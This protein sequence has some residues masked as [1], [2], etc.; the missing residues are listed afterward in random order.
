MATTRA[1]K[2]QVTTITKNNLKII[3]DNVLY[4]NG[5][6]T[7][8]YCVRLDNYSTASGT[9]MDE[10][11]MRLVN[12][13]S[14]LTLKTPEV[15]FTIERIEKVTEACNV[16]HNLIDTV[17]MYKPDYDLPSDFSK[18]VKKDIQDYCL[19]GIDI[20]QSSLVDVEDYTM[21]ET[22]KAIVRRTVNS[23]AGLG[24]MKIDPE[25]IL[26]IE[27]GIYQTIRSN[28]VRATREL[29]FYNY[30]SKVYPGYEISYDNNGWIKG[31][32]YED[33]MGSLTQTVSDNFGWFEL[34]NEGIDFFG[35]EPQN[36][37][38]CMIDIKAFPP[39]IRS[40][41]N[42]LNYFPHVVTTIK[43][44][45]KEDATIKL[46]RTRASDRYEVDQ[47]V[48]AGAEIEQIEATE[49]NIQ[50]ATHAIEGIEA[51]EIMCQFNTSIL[52]IEQSYEELKS[53]IVDTITTC[54]DNNL[55]VAKSLN[56]ALDFLDV[57]VNKKPKKLEHMAFL[58]FP[59]SFKQNR[60]VSVGDD[61]PTINGQL[62]WSPAIGEDLG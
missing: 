21:L 52:L 42:A 50:I 36:T 53:T 31:M 4:N 47:A 2:P 51:G 11:V 30:V 59:L 44:M 9:T 10:A 16:K 55:M 19:L 5:I 34:H 49:R 38:G 39:V 27:E 35:Y 1:T 3:G 6:I 7:A 14:N 26:K 33:I 13:I 18:N 43:C 28:C 61:S 60:G 22:A 24:N 54:K 15:L 62:N 17:K 58:G 46:K 12:M 23:F 8:F 41:F 48:E 20:Q 25:Q 37:Y 29:V 40:D 56:Q 45:K 32:D 57:Y